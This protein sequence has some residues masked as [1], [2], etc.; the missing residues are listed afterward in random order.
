[1]SISE[2]Y[3]DFIIDNFIQY[4]IK[5]ELPRIEDGRVF[6]VEL[7]I[8]AHQEVNIEVLEK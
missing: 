6:W 7:G 3:I 1:M 5:V 8:V 2:K 4:K